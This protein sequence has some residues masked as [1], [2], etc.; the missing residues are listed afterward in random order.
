MNLYNKILLSLLLLYII[1]VLI[2]IK[3]EWIVDKNQRYKYTL[4]D[5]YNYRLGDVVKFSFSKQ[6][7]N[8]L[9]YFLLYNG[10][11]AREYM[12][13]TYG[14]K[15]PNYDILYNI[16][17]KRKNNYQIP[18]VDTLIIHLR[19]GDV[20][21][22]EWPGDIDQLLEGK[23]D[24]TFN[25]MRNYNYFE[26][27][28]EKIKDKIKKIVLVGGFHTDCDHT[29]SWYYINKIKDFLQTKGYQIELR[30]DKYGADEDFIYMSNSEY[31]IQ[32]GG[33]YSDTI[34]KMVE[35]NN[36]TLLY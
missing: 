35:K 23:I 31:F 3:T 36:K 8:R 16:I 26:K 29:R 27:N 12:I 11:I 2:C 1:F 28:I 9:T 6:L 14:K 19:V 13:E 10:S 21:D 24:D 33:G 30:I 20:I 32:A 4:L 22:W 7:H 5:M 25:Y 34:S 15:I 18:N 17:K